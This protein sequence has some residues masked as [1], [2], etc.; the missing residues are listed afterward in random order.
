MLDY[1]EDFKKVLIGVF[2]ASFVFMGVSIGLSAMGIN[3]FS[4]SE[5]NTMLR[6][7][8]NGLKYLIISS[9][10]WF[11]VAYLTKEKK[12]ALVAFFIKLSFLG[13]MIFQLLTQVTNDESVLSFYWPDRIFSLIAYVTFGLM[14]FKNARGL[15]MILVFF[16]L[17]G[18]GFGMPGTYQIMIDPLL[19]A[20]GLGGIM[21]FEISAGEGSYTYLNVF[22][23]FASNLNLLLEVIVFW[24]VYTAIRLGNKFDISLRTIKVSQKVDTVSFSIIYLILGLGLV[25][26][27]F[28]LGHIYLLN[29]EINNEVHVVRV[30]EV[31]G[32]CIGIYIIASL[33]RNFIVSFFVSKGFYPRWLYLLLNIPL[34]NV[35][36]WIILVLRYPNQSALDGNDIS[37]GLMQVKKSQKS[38]VM[39]GKN[40]RIK[41]NLF[42]FIFAILLII[43][44]QMD[45]IGFKDGDFFRILSVS[46][47]SIGLI[48]WYFN[49]KKAAF[50]LLA[51][52]LFIII[53]NGVFLLDFQMG[54]V[55]ILG[56]ANVIVYYPLFHFDRFKFVG[57]DDDILSEND[58]H[59][60]GKSIQ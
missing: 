28:A 13:Y 17:I 8:L 2:V 44:V 25:L 29:E 45:K 26:S 57:S 6:I 41:N 60:E 49:D 27:I 22:Y 43:I 42:L 54:V 37:V 34:I 36:A 19:S 1:T 18:I 33:Y 56:L 35:F 16:A 4:V 23:I 21:E 55:V 9:V 12:A 40:K 24:F 11:A 30:F 14:A 39:D 46:L 38:F 20:V 10:F 50:F 58:I 51:I 3:Y 52:Q 32:L 7:I 5:P 59:V 15:Y 53:L 47:S 48:F 31:I